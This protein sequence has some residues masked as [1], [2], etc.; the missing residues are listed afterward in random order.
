MTHMNEIINRLRAA[1]D[2]LGE[3]QPLMAELDITN[4]RNREVVG[5][6]LDA[7]L[8]IGKARRLARSTAV[9]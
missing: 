1:D 9:R 3:L 4:E 7:Y 5:H 2:A 8:A 6:W